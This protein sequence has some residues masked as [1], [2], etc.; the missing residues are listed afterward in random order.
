[1]FVDWQLLWQ[2]LP[3]TFFEGLSVAEVTVGLHDSTQGAGTPGKSW[4]DKK[5]VI[6]CQFST[7]I[8][9][10]VKNLTQKFR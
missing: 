2:Y 4:A 9:I 6:V 1:M 3:E 7:K 5:F 8:Q 10:F